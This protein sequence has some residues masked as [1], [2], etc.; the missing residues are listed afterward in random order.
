MGTFKKRVSLKGKRVMNY[1]VMFLAGCLC[2]A[3][4]SEMKKS[5][6]GFQEV[7]PSNTRIVEGIETGGAD[8][9]L[10]EN[11]SDKLY[12]DPLIEEAY[13]VPLETTPE[14]LFAYNRKTIVYKDRIYV[15]DDVL[16]RAVFIFDMN[17]KFLRK[18]GKQGGAPNEFS[19]LFGMAVDE[20]NDRLVLFDQGKKKLLHFTLEGDYVKTTDVNF[21]FSGQMEYF[22]SGNIV[23]A[24]NRN[25]RNIHLDELDDYRILQSDS[26]GNIVKAGFKRD[27]NKKLKIIYERMFRS[28]EDIVYYPPF[29]NALYT[30][31]DDAISERYVVEYKDYPP[32]DQEEFL[33]LPNMNR[34]QE[35]E[36]RIVYLSPAALAENSTHLY[37]STMAK[38]RFFYTIYDKRAKKQLSFRNLHFRSGLIMAPDPMYSYGDYFIGQATAE[39]II[40]MREFLKREGRP[41]SPQYQELFNNIREDDNPVL[42]FFKL[43]DFSTINESDGKLQE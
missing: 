35:F 18:I 7:D 23:V 2:L 14:S 16:A 3:S 42:V 43:K 8:T 12:M 20:K 19:L 17:G 11:V 33:D 37:F 34:L 1:S 29:L 38:H 41:I 6:N 39:Q 25:F 30:I 36:G 4:C 32:I 10:V 31:G 27:D 21:D 24:T 5:S 22:P 40:A 15:M 9:V 28:G 26:L 13:Y